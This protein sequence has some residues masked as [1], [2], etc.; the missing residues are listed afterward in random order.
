[1]VAIQTEKREIMVQNEYL[2]RKI[3]DSPHFVEKHENTSKTH[4]KNQKMCIFMKK[5]IHAYKVFLGR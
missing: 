3:T 4:E 2:K 5:K 1:M